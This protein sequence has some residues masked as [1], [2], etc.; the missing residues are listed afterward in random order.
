M[1]IPAI[2]SSM[3]SQIL[4]VQRNDQQVRSEFKQLGEDLH[5]GN[6][7]QAQTDIVTLSKAASSAFGSNNSVVKALNAIGQALQSGSLSSAQ[8]AYSPLP[9]ALVGPC[10]EPHGQIGLMQSRFQK[11]LNQLGQMLQSSNR[12]GAQQA[13]S[14]VQQMWNQL[15]PARASSNSSAIGSASPKA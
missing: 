7:T 9:I 4:S 12:S 13:F 3:L 8:Q 15:A 6:L 1:C 11:V 10:A 5:S 2:S 14:A